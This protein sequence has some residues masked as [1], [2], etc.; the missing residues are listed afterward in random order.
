MEVLNAL[1]IKSMSLV[2][3]SAPESSRRDTEMIFRGATFV[4]IITS[5]TLVWPVS[6]F[7]WKKITVVFAFSES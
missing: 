7:E 3:R 4:I 1:Q 5:F 6:D 2:N